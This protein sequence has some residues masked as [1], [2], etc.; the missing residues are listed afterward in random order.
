MTRSSSRKSTETKLTRELC[1]ALEKL[2][3][4]TLSLTASRYQQPGWPDR[5]VCHRAFTGW[6]EFKG[7]DT[8]VTPLQLERMRQINERSPGSAF[9]VR[10]PDR[11]EYLGNVM[12]DSWDGTASGLLAQLPMLVQI[13]RTHAA[14]TA[15]TRDVEE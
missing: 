7:P 4:L 12:S 11:V 3:A 13:V 10:F 9:V 8:Q 5:W 1:R 14:V 6:L 2:G 15:S